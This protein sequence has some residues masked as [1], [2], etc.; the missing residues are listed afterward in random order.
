MVPDNAKAAPAERRGRSNGRRARNRHFGADGDLGRDDWNMIIGLG[1]GG[2]K[3]GWLT[4]LSSGRVYFFEIRLH[5]HW[6]VARIGCSGSR[7][8]EF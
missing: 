4:T 6:I 2:N 8:I 7:P 1:F 5:F 3:I